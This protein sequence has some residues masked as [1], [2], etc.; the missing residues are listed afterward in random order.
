MDFTAEKGRTRRRAFGGNVVIY[1]KLRALPS[2]VVNHLFICHRQ[3]K[4][5]GSSQRRD[6]GG[7][8]VVD[9]N[10]AP[11][12]TNLRQTVNPADEK[13]KGEK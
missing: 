12:C 7:N 3:T 4:E 13:H 10:P 5:K 2:S 8:T 1:R 9:E 11:N 6:F